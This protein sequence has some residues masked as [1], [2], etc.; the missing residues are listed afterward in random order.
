MRMFGLGLLILSVLA[1][2]AYADT[3]NIG[4]AASY[5]VLGEAGVTNTGPSIIDGDVGG[6]SGTP[7]VTGFPPG[8]VLAPFS[9]VTGS[10]TNFNDATTA[11]NTAK[12]AGG[13]IDLSG[14][15]LGVG[16]QSE[17]TAGVYSFSS[18]ASL[19]GTLIL[20]AGGDDNASWVFQ[21]GSSLTTASASSVE[22]INAGSGPFTGSITWAVTSGATLGTTTTFLGTIIS[23]AQDTLNTGATIGCGRVIALDAEVT[24]DDNIVDTP[25]SVGCAVTGGMVTP[26]PPLSTPEGGSTLL[27]LGSLLVPIGA[28]RAFRRRNV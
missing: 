8:M 12:G 2:N 11:Y 18:T 16:L 5:G 28:L 22:V 15:T 6:S 23:L 13:A 4:T 26:P 19:D 21:I 3:I 7:S 10:V 17:L 9:V 25:P 1:L 14:D 24:L 20:N 27:Y